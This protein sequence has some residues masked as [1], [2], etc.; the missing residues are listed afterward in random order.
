S[1]IVV[2]DGGTTIQ[3]FALTAAPASACLT[4][5]TQS[6]F[7][8]GVLTNVDLNSSPGA[9]VLLNGATVD[10]S[11]TAGT[12]TGTGFDATNWTGQTF[13]AGVRG[14][15]VKPDVQ[16]FCVGCGATPPDLTLSVRNTSSGL[17]TGADLTTATIPGS[18]FASGGTVTYTATFGSPLSLTSGTQ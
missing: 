15:L 16:L 11:N 13:V 3:N 8:T 5:T 9:V 17:P 7:Q 1:S 6:D 12:T 4:D 10:Q 14:S 2:T 18:T